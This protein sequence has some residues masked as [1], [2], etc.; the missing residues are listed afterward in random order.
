[1]AAQRSSAHEEKEMDE[2]Q[3]Q[4]LQKKSEEIDLKHLGFD[5]DEFRKHGM[6]FPFGLKE[7]T[8]NTK[9]KVQ[10]PSHKPHKPHE[11]PEEDF[12]M[13]EALPPS[14]PP[15][16]SFSLTK[17][18]PFRSL[19]LSC[20]YNHFV[21]FL[22]ILHREQESSFRNVVAKHLYSGQLELYFVAR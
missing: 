5:W 13:K 4:S 18:A 9:I 21:H 8:P 15:P 14:S 17:I 12:E 7:A 10:A 22:Q 6:R 16:R 11:P 19:S 20:S 2:A 3:L 1:M